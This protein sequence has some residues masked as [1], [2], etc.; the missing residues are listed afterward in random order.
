M[1]T[2]K[3]LATIKQNMINKKLQEEKI[4]QSQSIIEDDVVPKYQL[5]RQRS[6]SEIETIHEVAH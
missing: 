3:L 4:K 2:H 1:V 6:K 5:T